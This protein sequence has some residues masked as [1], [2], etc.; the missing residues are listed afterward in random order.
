MD[1][2]STWAVFPPADVIYAGHVPTRRLNASQDS[3]WT[4]TGRRPASGQAT[5]NTRRDLGELGWGQRAQMLRRYLE[6][7]TLVA[8]TALSQECRVASLHMW[9]KLR[10]SGGSYYWY[11]RVQ[12]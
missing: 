1:R 4:V 3:C 7:Q 5:K 8:R 6:V 12:S 11:L 9:G 10:L 2:K